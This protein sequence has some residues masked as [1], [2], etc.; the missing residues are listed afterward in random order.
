M[1]KLYVRNYSSVLLNIQSSCC[2]SDYLQH[3]CRAAARYPTVLTNHLVQRNAAQN[4][5]PMFEVLFLAHLKMPYVIQ[6]WSCIRDM[7]THQDAIEIAVDW[8]KK[9]QIEGKKEINKNPWFEW[10]D[11]PLQ[12]LLI[13]QYNALEWAAFAKLLFHQCYRLGFSVNSKFAISFVAANWA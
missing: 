5:G 3:E 12:H 1:A 9:H 2:A 6:F 4:Y 8:R 7:E 11:I 10:F 13:V